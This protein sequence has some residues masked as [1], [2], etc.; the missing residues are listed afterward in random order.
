MATIFPLDEEFVFA[1]SDINYRFFLFN[2]HQI[3]QFAGKIVFR[4]PDIEEHFKNCFLFRLSSKKNPFQY[5]VL[6]Q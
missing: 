4:L 2:L 3:Q 5:F 6:K 1:I